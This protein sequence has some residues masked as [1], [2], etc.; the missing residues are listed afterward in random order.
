MDV[1]DRKVRQPTIMRPSLEAVM[2]M[3]DSD[4]G[5]VEAA[6]EHGCYTDPDG[7]CPHGKDSW[8]LIMGLI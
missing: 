5:G 2:E 3:M 4:T 6:C 8:A 1:K 7:Q